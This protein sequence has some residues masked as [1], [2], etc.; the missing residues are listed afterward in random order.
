MIPALLF[1]FYA[2]TGIPWVLFHPVECLQMF[3]YFSLL[4]FCILLQ[5]CVVV[6][7]IYVLLVCVL[8]SSRLGCEVCGVVRLFKVCFCLHLIKSQFTPKKKKNCLGPV[9]IILICNFLIKICHII[10][11]KCQVIVR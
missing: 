6:V 8:L 7:L 10:K 11:I 3:S 1:C 9:S 4:Y 5:F 2:S